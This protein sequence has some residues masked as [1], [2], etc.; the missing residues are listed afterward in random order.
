MLLLL[1]NTSRRLYGRERE[2]FHSTC[3][4]PDTTTTTTTLP[5]TLALCRRSLS[6]FGP[7]IVSIGITYDNDFVNN[8]QQDNNLSTHAWLCCVLSVVL[9][10]EHSILFYIER[11]IYIYIIRPIY[12]PPKITHVIQ[13]TL[14][15][16]PSSALI[17][18][19]RCWNN[20]Q[21]ASRSDSTFHSVSD[22]FVALLLASFVFRPL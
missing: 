15:L 6:C 8:T 9:F 13:R 5:L 17:I 10:I 14:S 11:T 20:I 18:G 19:T 3:L 7:I 1:L 4:S 16:T 21:H 22:W 2:R 12:C